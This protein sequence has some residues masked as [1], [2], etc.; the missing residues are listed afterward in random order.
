MAGSGQFLKEKYLSFPTCSRAVSIPSKYSSR[1]PN[2]YALHYRA[3]I[4]FRMHL[5]NGL[6]VLRYVCDFF[7]IT[8]AGKQ[9]STSIHVAFGLVVN[10]V[11]VVRAFGEAKTSCVVSSVVSVE[12]AEVILVVFAL[13]AGATAS[14]AP[15]RHTTSV[16]VAALVL[17]QY[18]ENQRK[19]EK[20]R[21]KKK[22]KRKK[23]RGDKEALSFFFFFCSVIFEQ[24]GSSI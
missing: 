4:H 12:D 10:A 11:F 2:C 7:F 15:A 16:L 3:T 24:V 22:R 8:L 1:H 14:P 5:F 21:D 6:I 9:T 13:R 20:Q 18:G 19:E 23:N 17:S